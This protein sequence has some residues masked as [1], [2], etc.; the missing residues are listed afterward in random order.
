MT[1]A[2]A[3]SP[4]ADF[5]VMLEPT[6]LGAVIVNGEN[7]SH[8]VRRGALMFSAGDVPTLQ[9]ELRGSGRVEGQGIVQ[10]IVD[11][12]GQAA[13][14]TDLVVAF[15]DSVDPVR[16]TDLALSAGGGMGSDPVSGLLAA[17]KSLAVEQSG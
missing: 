10:V 13:T 16:L 17:L 9:L 11:S 2:A 4:F 8:H 6:G 5:T 14:Q 3:P 7:H 15:L 1:A 12:D